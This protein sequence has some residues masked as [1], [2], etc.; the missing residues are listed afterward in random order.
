[1]N[2]CHDVPASISYCVLDGQSRGPFALMPCPT[3]FSLF[4][5]PMHVHSR[6]L[7]RVSCPVFFCC[8][9]FVFGCLL[10]L[11]WYLFTKET[12]PNAAQADLRT[13]CMNGGLTRAK[14]PNRSRQQTLCLLQSHHATHPPSTLH[15][16]SCP[17]T[18]PPTW[19]LQHFM[20]LSPPSAGRSLLSP[21]AVNSMNFGAGGGSA[22]ETQVENCFFLQRNLRYLAIHF[23]FSTLASNLTT[24]DSDSH[25]R[26]CW[27]KLVQDH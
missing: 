15:P 25:L 20:H 11:F 23:H 16:P 27:F 8:F 5:S 4:V 7:S 14:N 9:C 2:K 13:S 6:V 26:P 21:L 12:L 3:S 1:M 17:T 22:L 18:L 10:V 24:S 19:L